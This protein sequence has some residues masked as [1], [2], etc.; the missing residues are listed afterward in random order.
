MKTKQ[1]IAVVGLIALIG[2]GIMPLQKMAAEQAALNQSLFVKKQKQIEEVAKL[3]KMAAS[4]SHEKYIPKE[5]EELAFADD[6]IAIGKKNGVTTPANWDFKFNYNSE[7][8]AGQISVSFPIEGRRQQI[9]NFLGDVEKNSRFMGIK[10]FA[11]KTDASASLTLTK[12]TVEIYG[13]F[14]ETK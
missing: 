3:E 8:G 4:G 9:A 1:I 14:L 7:V 10:D 12:M 2:F 6:I 5:P 13:F 11:I